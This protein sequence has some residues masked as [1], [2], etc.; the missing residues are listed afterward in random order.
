M[1]VY[2]PNFMFAVGQGAAIPVVALL[3]LDLG[4]NPAVAGLIV[5]LRGLGTMLFDAPAGILVARIGERK[6]MLVASVVL[7]G[8][9]GAV[10]LRPSLPVYAGLV[11]LLGGCW[12]IWS[13]ARLS[14]ATEASPVAHRGR[15]MSTMGGVT[16]MGQSVGPFLAGVAVIPFGLAAPFVI[17]ALLGVIATVTMALSKTVDPPS[18][19]TAPGHTGLVEVFREHRSTF[20]TAGVAVVCIQALRASRQAIIPLWGDQIGMTASQISIIFGISSAMEVA[21]FYP[22]GMLMDRKG[23]K[24]ASVP[25]MALLSVGVAVIPL[26]SSAGTLIAVGVLIGLANGMGAGLNMTLASDLSPPG[27]RSEFLGLWRLITDAGMVGGPMLVAGITSVATLA[28]S[29]VVMGAVGALGTAVL[30]LAVP[31]TRVPDP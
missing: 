1:A 15:V 17:Q 28:A 16:R 2:L 31:E 22:M 23:R 8:V 11:F 7:A 13:L 21:I 26:T 18:G 12:S 25:S 14:Y 10:G 5:A 29:A 27:A 19:R 4:V 3:A 24:W 30:W 9:A 6:S 20:A